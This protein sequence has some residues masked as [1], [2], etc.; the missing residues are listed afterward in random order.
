MPAKGIDS[1]SREVVVYMVRKNGV[2][3]GQRPANAQRR[4][5]YNDKLAEYLVADLEKERKKM[6]VRREEI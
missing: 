5:C 1:W 6:E 2:L 4:R 3:G